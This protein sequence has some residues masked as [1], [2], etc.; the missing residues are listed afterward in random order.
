MARRGPYGPV[1][2]TEFGVG[3]EAAELDE[4]W[5]LDAATQEEDR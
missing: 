3:V 2:E 5:T 4:A 1:V